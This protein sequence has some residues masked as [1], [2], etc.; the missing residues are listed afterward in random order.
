[1]S[2][3]SLKKKKKTKFEESITERTKLRMQKLDKQPDST[4]MPELESEEFAA[5]NRNQQGKG[6]K[7]LTPNQILIRVPIS[8]TQLKA[9][10]VRQ[11]SLTNLF[12]SLL[13]NLIL[14]LQITKIL[15]QLI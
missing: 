11:M 13:T 6:L 12:F 10:N 3:Q 5:Q 7:I 15:D 2:L 8:L 1:M 9:G 14:K 4:D